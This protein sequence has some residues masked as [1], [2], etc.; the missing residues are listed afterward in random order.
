MTC[1]F[2]K[3]SKYNLYIKYHTSSTHLAKFNSYEIK[4]LLLC[5]IHIYDER[6][7]RMVLDL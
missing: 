1:I 5:F 6:Y 2:P 7:E 4:H 3:N